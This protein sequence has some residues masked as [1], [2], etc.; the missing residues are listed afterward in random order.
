MLISHSV[1]L[2][3]E[4]ILCLISFLLNVLRFAL[5]SREQSVLMNVLCP[6]LSD[7]PLLFGLFH[8]CHLGQVDDSDLKSSVIF[9][10]VLSNCSV[11]Y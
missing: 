10:A 7:I 11:N 1:P 2:L 5:L 6:P 9:T 3:S 8:K 4:T